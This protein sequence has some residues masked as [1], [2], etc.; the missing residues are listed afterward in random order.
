M[1]E[2]TGAA[3]G[4]DGLQAFFAGRQGALNFV[5]YRAHIRC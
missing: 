4:C 1:D 5:A 3:I 2:S